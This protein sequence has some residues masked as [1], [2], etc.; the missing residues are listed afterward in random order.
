MNTII[1]PL[2]AAC[3]SFNEHVTNNKTSVIRTSGVR[4]AP[5]ARRNPLGTPCSRPWGLAFFDAGCD[6]QPHS[7]QQCPARPST[8]RLA[9]AG[10]LLEALRVSDF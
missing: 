9:A 3:V 1:D 2:A 8:S 5:G 4:R 6:S 10:S 7:P